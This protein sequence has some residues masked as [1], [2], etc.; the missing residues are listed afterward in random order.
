LR[1]GH[2]VGPKSEGALEVG[3]GRKRSSKKAMKKPSSQIRE[4]GVHKGTPSEEIRVQKKPIT[5]CAW[6]EG[7]RKGPWV[8][9]HRKPAPGTGGEG[10]CGGQNPAINKKKK[11]KK[12]RKK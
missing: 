12:K 2:G 11:K 9:S 1:T 10:K 5:P 8:T 7:T 3:G 6:S 4:Y